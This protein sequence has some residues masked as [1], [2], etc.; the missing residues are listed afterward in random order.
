MKVEKE[1]RSPHILNT[2]A[3]LLGFCFI[4]LTS[5]KI[6]KLEESSFI[7]EGAALAI[8]IFMSSCLL[9]FLA[10][11]STTVRAS[12]MERGADVL[13]LVGL[14]VLF[15]TTMLIAFNIIK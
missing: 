13:F 12:K 5:V 15:I 3:N 10:M 6:S 14:I 9:S 7:D 4:V 11:R 8:I 1:N 2:S